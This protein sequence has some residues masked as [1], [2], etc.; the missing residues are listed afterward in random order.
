MDG[1]EVDDEQVTIRRHYK[2]RRDDVIYIAIEVPGVRRKARVVQRR[3]L[4]RDVPQLDEFVQRVVVRANDRGG[5]EH[6]FIEDDGADARSGVVRTE[7]VRDLRH[8]MFLANARDI[9]AK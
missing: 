8:E 7:R 1:V 5:I 2:A 4:R 3:R 9:T 6:D